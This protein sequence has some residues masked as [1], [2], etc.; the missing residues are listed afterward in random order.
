MSF[1]T[2]ER[3]I[4]I[5]ENHVRLSAA[6]KALFLGTT[7]NAVISRSH[8]IGLPKLTR[9]PSGRPKKAREYKPS[10]VCKPPV[11]IAP[12]P[13]PVEP[14]NIPFIELGPKHCREIVGYGDYGLSLSCGHSVI[15]E[16]S[17]C[18]WHHSIN[19]MAAPPRKVSAM[20]FAA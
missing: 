17:F 9:A 19:H 4:Y 10:A 12:P 6:E 18:R 1:W 11:Q 16:G 20:R 13:M 15:H 3:D 2:L 7:R 8:R 5:T 14:L